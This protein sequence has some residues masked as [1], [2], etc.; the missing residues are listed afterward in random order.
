M[1][2]SSDLVRQ[3][4]V[5]GMLLAAHGRKTLA[6]EDLSE[7]TAAL[8]LSLEA[9]DTVP[10]AELSLIDNVAEASL[11]WCWSLFLAQDVSQLAQGAARLQAARAGLERAHGA[12][13]SRLRQLSGGG[14]APQLASHVRLNLLEGVVAFLRGDVRAAQASLAAAAQHARSF[15]VDPDTLAECVSMGFT[16]TEATRGLRHCSGNLSQAADWMLSQRDAAQARTRRREEERRQRRELRALGKTRSGAYVDAAAV[17]RL[18]TLGYA[19]S[20]AGAALRESDNI[21]DAALD[22]LSDAARNDALQAS[23]ERK[24]KR[25][26]AKA[27]SVAA[28]PPLIALGFSERQVKAALRQC[29]YDA[30]AAAELLLLGAL[31][32]EPHEPEQGGAGPAEN[33]EGGGAADC[34]P[35]PDM[36]AELATAVKEDPL[37]A[38][39]VDISAEV[40]AIEDYSARI[41]S[42]HAADG[43]G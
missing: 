35:D 41:R 3:A 31:P 42:L 33:D 38:Y 2:F 17:A 22:I 9:F 5:T 26:D 21:F 39:D 16:T 25:A 37:A 15:H 4:V 11:D 7:A 43:C 6:E 34:A 12:D 24:R 23:L 18:E 30:N 20:L 28:L 13:L 19:R 14:F 27:D 29:D 1:S 8:A 32:D 36:E 10:S 40:N